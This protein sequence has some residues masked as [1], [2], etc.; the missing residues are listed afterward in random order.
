MKILTIT[1][2]Y[3]NHVENNLGVFI[4]TRLNYLREKYPEVKHTVIA[5]VPWF[6]F[7]HSRFGQYAKHAQVEHFEEREGVSVYHPKYIVIPKIGMLLTPFFMAI[8][9]FFLLKKLQKQRLTF[10]LIDGHYF[11]PDGVAIAL[12]AKHFNLPFT[13]TARGTDLNLIPQYNLPKKLICWAAKKADHCITVCAALKEVLL[14]F[15]IEDKKITVMR[16]GVNL[17]LFTPEI[18]RV[19]LRDKLNFT[20]TTLIS[21]GYLIERKGHHFIIESMQSLPDIDL[22][23]IGDGPWES[24]LKELAKHYG[25]SERIKF[26]G[27][28]PQEQVAQYFKAGDIAMLASSREGWANVLLE[29]MAC[30]TAVVATKVWGTPEV[31]AEKVAGVLVERTAEDIAKGVLTLLSYNIDRKKT[32]E[33]A[34]KFNW[35][36]TSDLQYQLF[37]RLLAK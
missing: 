3:P 37:N 2:L 28:L 24:K 4:Q 25:V 23:I 31:V 18:D 34:E 35:D 17:S 19:A 26:T 13:I 5:P 33:Y 32:R 14:G 1:S 27:S 36:E 9:L 10:D 30:G 8:S 7:K 6:P 15:G 12:V 16:N 21:V 11:Y 29:A 22:V 20:R